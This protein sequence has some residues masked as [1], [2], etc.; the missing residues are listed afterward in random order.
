MSERDDVLAAL[1]KAAPELRRD[2]PIRAL[3]M[4]GSVARDEAGPDSDLDML[5]EFEEPV[6]LSAFLALEDRLSVLTGRRVE[7]VSRPSLKPHVGR[8][9]LSELVPV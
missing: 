9:V 8:R 7:L 6:S 4:F 3:A 1:K 2:Y 5:V